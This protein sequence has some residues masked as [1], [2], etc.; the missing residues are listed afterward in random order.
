[1][2]ESTVTSKFQITIPKRIRERMGIETGD[3]LQ[4]ESEGD[5]VV[6]SKRTIP[7][8]AS[9]LPLAEPGRPV[10]DVHEWR[11]IAKRRLAGVDEK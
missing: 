4:F 5:Y 2:E 11:D 3:I 8:L 1:M 7:K 6:L 9:E 10:Q